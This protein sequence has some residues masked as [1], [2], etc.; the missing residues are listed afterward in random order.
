MWKVEKVPNELSDL[1]KEI[2]KQSVE[3]AAWFL[4][5]ACSKIQEDRDKLRRSTGK[6]TRART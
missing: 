1:A 2:F 5:V 6:Q 4:L 3:S